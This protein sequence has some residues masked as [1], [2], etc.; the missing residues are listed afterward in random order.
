LSG[1]GLITG[2]CEERMVVVV[3]NQRVIVEWRIGEFRLFALRE[4]RSKHATSVLNM[5]M[6][7]RRVEVVRC[8]CTAQLAL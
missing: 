8:C 5:L 2:G 7:A 6:D 3:V 1:D 4:F